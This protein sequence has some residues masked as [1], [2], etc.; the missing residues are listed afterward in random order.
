VEGALISL[1]APAA[2]EVEF[3]IALKQGGATLPVS[4]SGDQRLW[5]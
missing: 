4:G 2:G 1:F 5:T 3:V